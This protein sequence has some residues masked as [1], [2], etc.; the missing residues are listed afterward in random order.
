VRVSSVNHNGNA[1]RMAGY[2]PNGL[3]RVYVATSAAFPDGL[4]GAARAGT[5]GAPVLYVTRTSL[6]RATRNAIADLDPDRVVILGG[7][8]AVST[9]VKRA[10]GNALP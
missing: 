2:Y 1:A 7:T 5:K 8:G 9:S 4:S 10:L 3:S 6:P